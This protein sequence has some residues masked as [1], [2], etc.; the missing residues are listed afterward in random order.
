M[1]KMTGSSLPIKIDS[2]DAAEKF[3]DNYDTFLFDCDGVLW[4]GSSLLPNVSETLSLLRAKGKNLYFVTNNSTKSRNAYAKKFE[5]FGISV[6]EDQIFTSSYAAAL[7]VR[8]SLKLEPG[9]DKVWVAG[10]AGI[11]DELGLMGYETLGGTDPRLDE[12]FDSQNSPFL[13]NSL[14]PD[15]KCVVAGLDTRINYHRLAVSLQ[16]LQRTDV[17]FVATNLD[18][19]FPLK[20]MTLP[21]AGSIVQSLEKASGRTAVAC[22][23]P[24]QNMLKSI[25]AATNIDPSRT[26][27]V[28]DR[29]DTDM[30]FGSEGRLGTFLVLTGIETENNILNPDTQHTKPQYY[31]GSLS[32]L[33]ELTN[34]P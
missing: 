3:I 20:G 1:I 24:N 15:V 33:Y 18:S 19:T 11:I 17:S 32:L 9:K 12:P 27:M 10:E 4:L 14:D 21:G 31:A 16:Y 8:D 22:G 25:I 2:A 6:R 7:Y 13:V 29:L 26:C 5:S 28:G 30:K 34:V 23:K